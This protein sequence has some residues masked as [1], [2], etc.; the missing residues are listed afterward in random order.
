ML[1]DAAIDSFLTH[2]KVERRLSPNTVMA[3]SRDLS[4][5]S[6]TLE[7]AQIT[8]V[9]EIQA[10]HLRTLIAQCFDSGISMRSTSRMLSAIRSFCLFMRKER[11]ME[12]DPAKLLESPKLRATLP[13]VLSVEEV[14]KLLAMPVGKPSPT[15]IRDQTFLQLLYAS[16]MRISEMVSLD[17]HNLN[18]DAGY[19]RA[20]GKGSKERI[21]PIGSFA[22]R[23]LLDYMETARPLLLGQGKA[24]KSSEALFLSRNGLRLTRQDGWRCVKSAARR[25]HINKKVTPH[26]L[27]HS[28]ATHMLERG[29]D[30]RA[31]QMMLGH[32][33]IKTTQ[34]YT[35][36][37]RRHLQSLIEKFHPRFK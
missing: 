35:H 34:I 14:D 24:Q 20:F 31:V 21:V 13:Y 5:M 32:S 30:L 16:G 12:H 7:S 28:F 10:E 4:R 36:V 33:N 23:A 2:L 11:H 1:I 17:M 25:A 19:L 22:V 9:K 29:A 8:D 6:A 37:D 26:M 3:Y 15:V 27:R 18:L